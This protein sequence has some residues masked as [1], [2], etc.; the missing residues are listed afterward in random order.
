MTSI[1]EM[2]GYILACTYITINHF[3][4]MIGVE[5]LNWFN[6]ILDCEDNMRSIPWNH[7]DIY[8]RKWYLDHNKIYKQYNIYR[9]I[10]AQ[11]WI[12]H[13][14]YIFFSQYFNIFSSILD[15]NSN[16]V[17]GSAQ[18]YQKHK[19]ARE[20]ERAR[21]TECRAKKCLKV[22]DLILW[23]FSPFLLLSF[24]SSFLLFFLFLSFSLLLTIHPPAWSQSQNRLLVCAGGA[25]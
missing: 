12:R 7:D 25:K 23:I 16:L 24:F 14:E 18:S 13:R 10:V 15:I 6:N 2:G 22:L 9:M 20:R 5:Q 19:L 4:T 11:L 8:L 3:A 17:L 21:G 1:N